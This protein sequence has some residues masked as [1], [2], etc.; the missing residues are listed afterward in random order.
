[1][2]YRLFSV[3]NEFSRKCLLNS[4][5]DLSSHPFFRLTE[6]GSVN[7]P[8]VSSDSL[9][10]GLEKL[11]NFLQPYVSDIEEEIFNSVTPI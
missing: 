4:K 7:P 11:N 10:Q 6:L 9:N 8:K 2:L 3:S 1:M 5:V